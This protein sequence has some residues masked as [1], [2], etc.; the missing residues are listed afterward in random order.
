M[1]GCV[2]RDAEV[3]PLIRELFDLRAAEPMQRIA[4]MLSSGLEK[5]KRLQAAFALALDFHA[6]RRLRQSGL[7]AAE[8]ADLMAG[9]VL[10]AGSK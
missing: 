8:A 4:G 7:D 1:F 10:C 6:W 3:D 2:L 5:D 9:A